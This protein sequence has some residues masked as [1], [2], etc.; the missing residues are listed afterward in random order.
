MQGT[1]QAGE[2]T[3]SVRLIKSAVGIILRLFDVF[4]L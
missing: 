4:G 3:N 1:A 2:M